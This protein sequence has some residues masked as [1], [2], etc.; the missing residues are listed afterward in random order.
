[1]QWTFLPGFLR[2]ILFRLSISPSAN[3][4]LSGRVGLNLFSHNL[5]MNL[6]QS[7]QKSP[8][9]GTIIITVLEPT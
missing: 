2:Y 7:G 6:N 9:S 4:E 5:T 8:G 1:M 3:K